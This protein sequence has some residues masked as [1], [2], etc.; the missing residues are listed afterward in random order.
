MRKYNKHYKHRRSVAAASACAQN[1]G[2]YVDLLLDGSLR[3]KRG[4][5]VFGAVSTGRIG[6]LWPAPAT[7][8]PAWSAPLEPIKAQLPGDWDR[9]ND[10]WSQMDFE[11]MRQGT[12]LLMAWMR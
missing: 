11:Y 5:A 4:R 3:L 6:G 7:T 12:P 1:P 2:H 10:G 9:I 8:I